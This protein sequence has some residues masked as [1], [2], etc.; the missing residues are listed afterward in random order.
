MGLFLE[1]SCSMP[2]SKTASFG[3]ELLHK[4]GNIKDGIRSAVAEEAVLSYLC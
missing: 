2:G 3:Q 4:W 1:F